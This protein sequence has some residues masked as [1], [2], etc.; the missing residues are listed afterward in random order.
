[1]NLDRLIQSTLSLQRIP[2]PTF[3][4][5][6]RAEFMHN[7]FLAKGLRPV[8]MDAAGNVFARVAGGPRPPLVISAHLDTVFAPEEMEPAKVYNGHL[9]GPSVGDN[10]VA[11]AALIELAIDLPSR[12]LPGD[13]WLVANV[14]EEGLG[15]LLGMEHVVEKFGEAVTA[16]VVLEG[17]SLGYVYHRALPV[18]R[19]R[20]SARTAG[21]HAWIHAGRPSAIHN[22]VAVLNDLIALLPSLADDVSLNVGRIS[23][24]TT[25]NTIAA[26]AWAELDLRAIK[27][28][29]LAELVQAV[30]ATLAQHQH[31]DVELRMEAVGH[32]P[33]GGIPADHPLVTTALE[34]AR[35]AG[36]KDPSLRMGSTDASFPLS[37]GLPAVCIGLTRGGHAHSAREFIEIAPLKVGYQALLN[38]I[39][40]AYDAGRGPD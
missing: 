26:S 40:T 32:R 24:G 28:E 16:Y 38:L 31:E 1:M 5:D 21:G 35:R 39:Q 20:L 15:N 36:V 19:F 6:Q 22:L 10:S 4:E 37:L 8:E 17:M 33:G 29:E 34:A 25:V 27:D 23:G 13:V 30:E 14:A 11:L 12:S 9:R 2:A 18:R 7:A 3:R